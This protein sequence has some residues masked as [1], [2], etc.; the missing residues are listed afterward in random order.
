MVSGLIQSGTEIQMINIT[1]NIPTIPNGVIIIYEIRYRESNSNGSYNMTNT[2]NA[3]Y[4]IRGLLPNTNYTT[5]VRA[6][7][8][9]G[10]GEWSDIQMSTSNI[11]RSLICLFNDLYIFLYSYSFWFLY[12]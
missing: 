10:P 6:Y 1:W 7:T 5:G 2:T 8:S 11:R 4:S 3:Q 9:V 12:Y